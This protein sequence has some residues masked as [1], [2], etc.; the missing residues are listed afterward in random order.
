MLLKFINFETKK[1]VQKKE[2]KIHL[3]QKKICAK[4]RK[5]NWLKQLFK[6]IGFSFFCLFFLFFFLHVSNFL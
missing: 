2:K 4:K 6:P 5:T 3:K 1:S